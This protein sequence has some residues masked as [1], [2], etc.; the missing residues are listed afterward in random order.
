MR[1]VFLGAPGAGKGTQATSLAGKLG[2]PHISTGDI[3]RSNIKNG[4]ELGRKAK[5]YIDKGTL[6]PDDIT[7]DIIKDRI[8]YDDCKSGYILDG[9]PRNIPQAEYLDK[10]LESMGN[11]LDFVIDIRVPDEDIIR[12]LAV[13]WLCSNCTA[14]YNDISNP[15]KEKGRCDICGSAIIQREDDECE[16][17]R[18]R[19][20]TYHEQTEP[21]VHYYETK[22]KLLPV[23][24]RGSIPESRQRVADAF[25]AACRVR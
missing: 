6:V 13:R 16:T 10:T 1:I 23:D 25:D 3:F 4:T 5:E 22:G 7:V 9:Y 14:T 17:V 2:I 11:N 20:Q 12:R 8:Q 18:K 19:L 21:L 15:P 24:G